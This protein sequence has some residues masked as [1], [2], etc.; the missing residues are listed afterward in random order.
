MPKINYKEEVTTEIMPVEDTEIT[1]VKKVSVEF[2][3]ETKKAYFT[4]SDGIEVEVSCPKMKQLLNVRRMMKTYNIDK[5]DN[6]TM[7]FFFAVSCVTKYGKDTRLSYETFEE[8]E[9]QDGL[10]LVKCLEFFRDTLRQLE[11]II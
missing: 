9:L 2:D 1:T 10:T 7:A 11:S 5:D 8:L 3:E 4:T 6:E